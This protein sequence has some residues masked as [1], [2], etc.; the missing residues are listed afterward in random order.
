MI[1]PSLNIYYTDEEESKRIIV[2]ENLSHNCY[3]NKEESKQN[4]V[5]ET[6]SKNYSEEMDKLCSTKIYKPE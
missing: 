2:L 1:A 4:I 3:A 5:N 6:L